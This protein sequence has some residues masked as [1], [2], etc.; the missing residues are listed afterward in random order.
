MTI[1]WTKSYMASG[2][3]LKILY[4]IMCSHPAW[5]QVTKAMGGKT[6]NEVQRTLYKEPWSQCHGNKCH[7]SRE[8]FYHSVDDCRSHREP[9][10]FSSVSTPA[11]AEVLFGLGSMRVVTDIPRNSYK[12]QGSWSWLTSAV[13][14]TF[15]WWFDLSL[16]NRHK[17]KGK[18]GHLGGILPTPQTFSKGNRLHWDFEK[19]S[20]IISTM[21]SQLQSPPKL[22][23]SVLHLP[24]NNG[25]VMIHVFLQWLKTA[26]S[27]CHVAQEK[28]MTSSQPWKVPICRHT[29]PTPVEWHG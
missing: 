8:S 17:S 11:A 25:G 24:S 3:F 7:T 4:C 22:S 13:S 14:N 20:L 27:G 19:T 2:L 29:A 21:D 18:I 5:L 23:A 9:T 15:S 28:R 10:G 1:H 16:W 26:M 6:L 12:G